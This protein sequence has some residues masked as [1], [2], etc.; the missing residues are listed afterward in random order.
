MEAGIKDSGLPPT[1]AV[2]I[3]EG[4]HRKAESPRGTCAVLPILP[5]LCVD[6]F[7]NFLTLKY[8]T[9]ASIFKKYY[10]ICIKYKE[11]SL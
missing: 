9:F 11:V 10:N 2:C 3:R 4:L 5:H 7:T 6:T 8:F 1:L